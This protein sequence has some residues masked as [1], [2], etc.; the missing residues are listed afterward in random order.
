MHGPLGADNAL[1][2]LKAR[3]ELGP[4][5]PPSDCTAIV[6]IKNLF[7][8]LSEVW[9]PRGLQVIKGSGSGGQGAGNRKGGEVRN[10]RL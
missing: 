3:S 1:S 8:T 2:A 9:L 5:G 7:D 10:T 6:D 4:V